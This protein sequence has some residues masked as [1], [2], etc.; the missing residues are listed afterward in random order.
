MA[1]ADVAAVNGGGAATAAFGA[2]AALGTMAALG[3][4]AA[5]GDEIYQWGGGAFWRETLFIMGFTSFI[6][7]YL[8]E[9]SKIWE[10]PRKLPGSCQE[11]HRKSCL[12]CYRTHSITHPHTSRYF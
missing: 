2:T 1:V 6:L 11:V 4:V 3:A 5:V 9:A 12:S 8:D 7:L 10:V